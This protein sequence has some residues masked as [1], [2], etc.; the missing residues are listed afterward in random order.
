MKKRVSGTCYTEV[1]CL[2]ICF[3][4]DGYTGRLEG[5]TTMPTGEKMGL[6]EVM[7]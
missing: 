7:V 6:A 1:M 3:S 4:L 5:S 2:D